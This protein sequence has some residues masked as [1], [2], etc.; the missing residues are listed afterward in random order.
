MR[1]PGAEPLLQLVQ[2][3][4]DDAHAQ[5]L[6][7][8]V[9]RAHQTRRQVRTQPRLDLGQLRR[10]TVGGEDDAAIVLDQRRQGV[11]QLLLRRGL[12]ADEMHVVDQQKIGPA[13]LVLEGGGRA[14]HDRLHEGRGELL[15]RQIDDL[16]LR[17][18]RLRLP[19]DGVEEVGLAVTIGAVQEDRIE[20]PVGPTGHLT[21]HRIGEL[22]AAPG[23]ETVEGQ[24]L[25][26]AG[27]LALRRRDERGRRFGRGRRRGRGAGGVIELNARLDVQN[28]RLA[29]MLAPQFLRAAQGV[30][31][32][33]VARVNGRRHQHRIAVRPRLHAR[34]RHI[35]IVRPFAQ[36]PAQNRRHLGPY[37]FR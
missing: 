22:V 18:A 32:D 35:G 21:R 25:L 7:R 23:D 6:I 33:P 3:A 28:A 17:A 36:L 15:R 34:R 27:D 8:H 11:E 20:M 19:A 5:S 37:R 29:V 2:L 12:A 16:R 1:H 4:L 24:A 10:R 30:A 9:Q 13:H 26:Q 31:R 14:V